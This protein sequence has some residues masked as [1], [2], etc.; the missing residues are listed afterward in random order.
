[1][2]HR[3]GKSLKAIEVLEQ[4]LAHRPSDFD[5]TAVNILCELLIGQGMFSRALHVLESTRASLLPSAHRQGDRDRHRGGAD[6]SC[7]HGDGDSRDGNS[8]D[9]NSSSD[10][11]PVDLLA[12][13]AVCLVR[14]GRYEEAQVGAWVGGWLD[15]RV[16]MGCE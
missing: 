1:M 4:L 13:Q 6:D 7:D 16:L 14:T 2:Y 11:F 10:V 3:I 12:K 9:G 15:K 5:L 8:R